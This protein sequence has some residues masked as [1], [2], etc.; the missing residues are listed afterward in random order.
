M[1]ELPTAVGEGSVCVPAA[2]CD[3]R[4]IRYVGAR[5]SA[6]Y[7]RINMP[8]VRVYLKILCMLVH[9]L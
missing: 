2:N 9:L 8:V 3:S 6:E 4:G 1:L 5:F 7:V